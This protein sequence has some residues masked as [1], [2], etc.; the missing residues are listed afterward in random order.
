M[1]KARAGQRLQMRGQLRQ[2]LMATMTCATVLVAAADAPKDEDDMYQYEDL[3]A[4][5]KWRAA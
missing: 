2:L 4:H 3:V 1:K 5:D